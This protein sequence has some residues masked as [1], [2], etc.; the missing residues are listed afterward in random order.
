MSAQPNASSAWFKK[1]EGAL[2][3]ADAIYKSSSSSS[4]HWDL[5]LFLAHEAIEK[6]L[7]GCLTAQ[8]IAIPKTHDLLALLQLCAP[9]LPELLQ[10][11]ADLDEADRLY[12]S[13]RY[14]GMRDI[15]ESHANKAMETARR[16]ESVAL[17]RFA[18]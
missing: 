14:P 8:R 17:Q 11:E 3:G 9:L 15:S 5:V 10:L 2:F 4:P 6:Y 1:A 12:V 7:K 13:S 18:P 16:V